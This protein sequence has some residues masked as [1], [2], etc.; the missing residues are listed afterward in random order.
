MNRSIA[1]LF[2]LVLPV[3]AKPPFVEGFVRLDRFNQQLADKLQ[4]LRE[5]EE[6]E[7]KPF[8]EQ[9]LIKWDKG[10]AS[11]KKRKIVGPDVLKTIFDWEELFQE[12]PTDATKRIIQQLP[13]VLKLKYGN[14][15]KMGKTFRRERFLVGRVLI[16]Q[17]VKPPLHVRELAITCLE[18]IHKTRRQYVASDPKEKR[19]K[20]YKAWKAYIERVS[21]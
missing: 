1:L 20:R 3:A 7:K 5:A 8:P 21:K 16:G 17:L 14:I 11:F 10:A 6:F 4:N 15:V 9:L 19:V 12:P 18:E 13:E 2:L